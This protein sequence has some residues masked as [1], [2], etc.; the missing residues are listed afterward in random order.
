VVTWI[1]EIRRF[2]S[3][4]RITAS[5]STGAFRRRWDA[6]LV[7]RAVQHIGCRKRRC[8]D[9]PFHAVLNKLGSLGAS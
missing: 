1:A 7:G 9:S 3:L 8:C 6:H 2:I 4:W 5:F